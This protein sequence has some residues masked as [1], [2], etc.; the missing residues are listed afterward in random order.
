[1]NMNRS[2]DANRQAL[3]EIH[4]RV[5]AD[6]IALR[7]EV[8]ATSGMVPGSPALVQWRTEA[9][10]LAVHHEGLDFYPAFQ[11]DES[12]QPWPIIAELLTILRSGDIER[13]DW[14]N[15]LWFVCGTGWLDGQTP[16]GCMHSA[17]DAVRLAAEQE[18][19]SDQ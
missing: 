14:D 4:L 11:F 3:E 6:T 15:V 2:K 5:E 8:M 19:A 7:K 9:R 16:A 18:V 17:P 12:G 1:M 13:T 10:I